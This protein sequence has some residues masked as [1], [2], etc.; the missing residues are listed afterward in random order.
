MSVAQHTPAVTVGIPTYNRSAGLQRALTSVLGQSE[1]DLEV[2]VAD[3]ASTDD[4]RELI[5]RA[6]ADDGRIRYLRHAQNQG[7][8]ANFNAVLRAARGEYVMVLADDD[9]IEQDYVAHCRATLSADS[10]LALVSGSPV[11]HEPAGKT[12][13]GVD[14]DLLDRHPARRVLR[15]FGTVTDNVCIYGLMR[16]TLIDRVLPMRNCLAGDWL[17]IARLAFLGA[18]RTN[19][20]THVHRSTDGASASLARTVR[21]LG[22]SEFEERHPHLA[23]MRFIH[24][25]IAWESAVYTR[26]SPA[27]RQ[28]LALACAAQ[29]A[30][31]RPGGLVI[32]ELFS[33]QPLRLLYERLPGRGARAVS[34]SIP[35]SAARR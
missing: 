22:L 11:Y 4:T 20:D 34:G 16:R 31:K 19:S 33:R 5:E 17:L 23:I 8:T 12:F 30:R 32:E 29:V 15:Y 27:R 6:A 25:D 21:R 7:L 1:Q 24:S 35:E 10:R 18:V 2:I 9:W 3:N 28:A 13:P 14:I 26:L